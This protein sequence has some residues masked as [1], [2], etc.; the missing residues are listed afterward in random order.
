[1]LTWPQ[2]IRSIVCFRNIIC[3]PCKCTFHSKPAGFGGRAGTLQGPQ[4]AA[5][6]SQKTILIID[7]GMFTMLSTTLR[8]MCY[9]T[10]REGRKDSCRCMIPVSQCLGVDFLQWIFI[11]KPPCINR[12]ILP[13]N[14]RS[15]SCWRAILCSTIHGGASAGSRAERTILI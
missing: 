13:L 15:M 2:I 1:M 11:I 5:V 9:F 7:H 3:F 12:S 6:P 8:H 4:V 10:S 14:R